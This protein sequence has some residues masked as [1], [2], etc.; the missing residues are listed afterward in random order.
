MIGHSGTAIGLLRRWLH[1]PVAITFLAAYILFFAAAGGYLLGNPS[2]LP[3][4]AS[5]AAG[6]IF[7]MAALLLTMFTALQIAPARKNQNVNNLEDWISEI[8]ERLSKQLA[9]IKESTTNDISAH[10]FTGTDRQKLVDHVKS[11]IDDSVAQEIISQ[12]NARYRNAF[13][14]DARLKELDGRFE[15]IR[16]ELKEHISYLRSRGEWSLT[17]GAVLALGAIGVLLWLAIDIDLSAESMM[18]MLP[19][20]ILRLSLFAF[21][22]IFAFFFLRLYRRSLDE[23]K[24][25]QNELT[26]LEGRILGL[27]VALREGDDEALQE[28]VSLFNR[29]ERNPPIIDGLQTSESN[30]SH[31]DEFTSRENSKQH[32]ADGSQH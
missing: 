24:Y 3:F 30:H 19:I 25:Y 4:P 26:T 1:H 2:F 20:L 28:G 12:V 23:N 18:P 6:T 5:I 8:Y 27:E 17:A 7:L 32:K 16:H 22:Q 31:A 11:K 13:S 29:M 15:S 9:D 10:G 21:L 14:R